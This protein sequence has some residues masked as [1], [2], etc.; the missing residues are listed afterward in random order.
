MFPG[1]APVQRIVQFIKADSN[2]SFCVPRN[3]G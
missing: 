2:R 1:D 3:N